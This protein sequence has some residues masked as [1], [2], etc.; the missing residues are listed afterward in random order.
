M[1]RLKAGLTTTT[2]DKIVM[3]KGRLPQIFTI[4]IA[5]VNLQT[6]FTAAAT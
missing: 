2:M 1:A 3:A 5:P 6:N 4:R